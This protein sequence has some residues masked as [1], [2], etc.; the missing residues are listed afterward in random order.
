MSRFIWRHEQIP[1]NDP[2]D[3]NALPSQPG[4]SN[5]IFL[6]L[7]FACVNFAIHFDSQ[8]C[9]GA[10]EIEDIRPDGMLLPKNNSVVCAV[11]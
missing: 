7:K 9:L 3:V 2:M 1:R 6:L 10:V 4:V 5:S 11:S 8:F